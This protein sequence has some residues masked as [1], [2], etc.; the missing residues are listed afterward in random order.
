VELAEKIEATGNEEV[1]LDVFDGGH[2][3]IPAHSFEWFAK[4]A[5]KRKNAVTITG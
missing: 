2:E 4:L 5:G 1:Y 3:Q